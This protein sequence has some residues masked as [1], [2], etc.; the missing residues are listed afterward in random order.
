MPPKAGA[1]PAGSFSPCRT[2]PGFSCTE[3]PVPLDPSG[4]VP[5][6]VSLAVGVQH[7]RAPVRGTALLL[8]GGPGQ[9]ALPVAAQTAGVLGPALAGY[10]LVTFDQRGTG[11]S[12]AINCP[13]LQRVAQAALS[14]PTRA[15]S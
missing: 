13:A 10:R 9:A 4:A 11:L 8:A 1:A 12:G 7:T 2:A 15:S 3:V 5:G 6:T 14:V